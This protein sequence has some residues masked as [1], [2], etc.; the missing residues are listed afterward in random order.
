MLFNSYEFIFLFFPI[1]TAFYFLLGRYGQFFANLWLTCA[2]FFFYGWWNINYIP[3][4]LASICFNYMSGL[5]LY[6]FNSEGKNRSS[7]ALL[8]FAIATNLC[9]LG[10]FKYANF[11]LETIGFLGGGSYQIENL[12]LPL[13]ISFFTFTQI[14][15]LVDTWSN[16]TQEHKFVD[17]ALFVTYFPHLIAGP[18][19]HHQEI[20]PQFNRGAEKKFIYENFSIGL[21]VFTIGLFKK[22]IFADNLGLL[23]DPVFAA[24]KNEILLTFLD[25]WL[26]AIA[27]A[28]QLYFDF[29]GYTDMAIGMSLILGIRLPINF[30]SPYKANN[31]IE[32]WQRWHMTLSRFFKD[33]LY[34]PLGGNRKGYIR[35]YLN[36][37][38]TMILGGLWHGASWSF[39]AWGALHGFYLTIN[40]SWQVIMIKFNLERKKAGILSCA[41]GR[42]VT[43]LSVVIAWVF[44]RAENLDSTYQ[45]L[46]AMS[47]HNGIILPLSWNSLFSEIPLLGQGIEFKDTMNINQTKGMSWVVILLFAVWFCPNTSQI[48][49]RF[50]PSLPLK[51][52]RGVGKQWEF[53]VWKPN[54][55][56]AFLYC[57][58]LFFSIMNISKET[59]FLYYQ[60]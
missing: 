16:K 21:T 53:L 57:G 9:L 2:S 44:F 3:L 7:S 15:F 22:V 1:V 39:I 55:V 11:F 51:F 18:I 30:Y 56:W 24:H 4:L 10:Y 23:A 25:A 13:G 38:I 8:F 28:L 60:F 34:I 52:D 46:L 59:I 45:I 17:F 6:R 58:I 20:I 40:H 27:Y 48:M 54:M 31:I 35:S 19:L 49:H 43:F 14:T 41:F 36:L 50:N 42:I 29:S 32:F 33:Y 37:M 12:I 26:G 47:G 5:W